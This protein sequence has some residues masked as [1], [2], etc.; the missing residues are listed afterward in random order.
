[1]FNKVKPKK[2]LPNLSNQIHFR[3]DS[4]IDTQRDTKRIH[5]RRKGISVVIVGKY[6]GSYDIYKSVVESIQHACFAKGLNPKITIL[7]AKDFKVSELQQ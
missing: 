6:T 3:I 7:D 5:K 2:T 1:M 4:K